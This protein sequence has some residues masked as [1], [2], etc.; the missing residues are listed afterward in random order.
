MTQ[1]Q[2][3]DIKDRVLHNVSKVSSTYHQVTNSEY[4]STFQHMPHPVNQMKDS[5]ISNF[6]QSEN[7]NKLWGNRS[8]RFSIG[9][10]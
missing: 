7:E 2:M 9:S 5:Y 1:S 6:D 10:I 4:S 8:N 3:N